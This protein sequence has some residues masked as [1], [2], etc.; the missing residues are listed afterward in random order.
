MVPDRTEASRSGCRSFPF[1][2]SVFGPVRSWTGWTG[3]WTGPTGFSF[4]KKNFPANWELAWLNLQTTKSPK[5]F[6]ASRR[7]ICFR[8][9]CFQFYSSFSSIP[10]SFAALVGSRCSAIAGR[11]QLQ[12]SGPFSSPSSLAPCYFAQGFNLLFQGF[13]I[14]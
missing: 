3:S 12:W 5:L 9:Q 2:F 1:R 6:E 7:T 10:F 11:W 8:L 4:F 14:L 13:P